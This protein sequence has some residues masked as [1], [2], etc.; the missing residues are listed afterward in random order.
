MKGV[1]ALSVHDTSQAEFAIQDRP[2]SNH[3]ALLTVVIN[4]AV[5]KCYFRVGQGT[6]QSDER[7]LTATPAGIYMIVCH[8]CVDKCGKK[9]I[10]RNTIFHE[11][12]LNLASLSS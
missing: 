12:P 5:A 3:H 10:Q 2:K 7:H 4:F 6:H 8:G 11:K 1:S 9:Q